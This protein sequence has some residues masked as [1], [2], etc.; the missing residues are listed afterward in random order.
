MAATDELSVFSEADAAASLSSLAS[1]AFAASRAFAAVDARLETFE[2]VG[3][4]GLAAADGT[5]FSFSHVLNSSSEKSASDSD[6]GG[7]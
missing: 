2:N 1:F 6:R 7:L 5:V 4:L 3:F